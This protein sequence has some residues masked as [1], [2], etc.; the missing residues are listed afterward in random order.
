MSSRPNG[1]PDATACRGRRKP[2]VPPDAQLLGPVL[3]LALV[4][5]GPA[6]LTPAGRRTL[7][8]VAVLLIAG[9]VPLLAPLVLG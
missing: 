1:K 8:A 4:A 6:E 7:D 9:M 2:P 3:F 5:F